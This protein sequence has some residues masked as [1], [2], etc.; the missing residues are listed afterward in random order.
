MQVSGRSPSPFRGG[1]RGEGS[2]TAADLPP[3]EVAALSR[4]DYQAVRHYLER[5]EYLPA[6]AR[7]R[8]AEKLAGPLRTR[9]TWFEGEAPVDANAFL[10]LIAHWYERRHGT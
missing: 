5:R 9:L 10:E 3:F 4:A 2:T 1:G 8:V 6:A 7:E